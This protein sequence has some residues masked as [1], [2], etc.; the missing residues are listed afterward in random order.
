MKEKKYIL[1]PCGTSLLTNQASDKDIKSLIFKHANEKDKENIAEDDRLILSNLINSISAKIGNAS[2]EEAQAMSAELNGIIKIYGG[3][4]PKNHD[5]YL[6]LSTD[7]WLGGETAKLVEKWIKSN[8]PDAS[9]EVHKETDLQTKDV[10]AFQIALSE[11]VEKLYSEL[12]KFRE[13]G[14]KIIFNLTGGFKSVQGFLQSIANFFAD[15]SVY[16]F[17]TSSELLRIPRIPIKMDLAQAVSENITFFRNIVIGIQPDSIPTN[18]P[19]TFLFTIEG[20]ATLSAWAELIWKNYKDEIY[21]EQLLSS[22]RPEKIEYSREFEKAAQSLPKERLKIINER[23][24]QLNLHLY[25]E[26]N[27]LNSLDFKKL[28]GGPIKG[29]THEMDAWSDLDA[30]RIF[31]HFNNGCFIL[32]RIDKGLH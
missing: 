30:K 4:I 27:N 13:S 17:E 7:T 15:E 12:P 21:Q 1:S 3:V 6:L 23:I 5:T 14:Y 29:S 22:P 18:I 2:Y 9:V 32:D 11:L 8:N 20:K 31:G 28:E 26:N 16:I 24:D 25:N 10:L 19:E